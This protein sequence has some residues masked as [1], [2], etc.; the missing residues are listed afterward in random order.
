MS[1]RPK[2]SILNPELLRPSSLNSVARNPEL[3]WLDKNENLDPLLSASNHNILLSMPAFSLYTYPEAGDLYR[4]LAKWTGVSSDSFILT[5]GSDGAIR[6]VFDAF[7]EVG[8]SVV[9]TFPTFAMYPVYSQIFGAKVHMI[10]YERK[11]NVPHLNIQELLEVIGMKKPK[12]VCLPNPDSPTGTVISPDVL[13]TVLSACESAG[14]VLLIDEAYHPFYQWSA[15]KWTE[16][17]K[18]L[19]VAR[20]FAKAWGVAGLRIGYAIAHPDTVSLL[21][22]IRPMYETS[23]LAVDYISLLLDHSSEMEESVER[24]NAGKKFFE[25]EM[26]LMGFTISPALGNFSHVNFGEY[27]PVIH[28]ALKNKVLYRPSFDHPSLIGFSRFSVAP[29]AIMTKV[30]NW[31]KES[32]K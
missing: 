32:L 12:L 6:L 30:V 8:D 24:I 17:S 7:V 16:K 31:I 3:I 22:K 23:T 2:A 26:L 21:H 27:G 25:K 14:S 15:V 28:A 4:K 5:P 29:E 10:H 1:I 18:N 20:T 19:I 9:H 13:K 11:K